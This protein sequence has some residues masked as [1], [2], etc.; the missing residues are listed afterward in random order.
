MN[1]LPHARR[2]NDSASEGGNVTTWPTELAKLSSA[3]GTTLWLD[4]MHIRGQVASGALSAKKILQEAVIALSLAHGKEEPEFLTEAVPATLAPDCRQ[5]EPPRRCDAEFQCDDTDRD[6]IVS[7]SPPMN[8]IRPGTLGGPAPVSGTWQQPFFMQEQ[9]RQQPLYAAHQQ[10][11]LMMAQEPYQGPPGAGFFGTVSGPALVSGTWQLP[12]PNQQQV[13]SSQ[14][15]AEQ[16]LYAAHRQSPLIMA[17][18]PYQPPPGA[19]FAGA[20]GGPAPLFGMMHQSDPRQGQVP[21][22]QGM[23]H[24]LPAVQ[25][26]PPGMA[27]G[28]YQGPPGA[29]YDGTAGDP[30]TVLGMMHQPD[31]RQAQVPPPQGMFQ[32]AAGGAAAANWGAEVQETGPRVSDPD[33]IT[34][35]AQPH[36]AGCR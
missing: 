32:H 28:P 25:L 6:G 20:V 30:G 26:Q 35:G 27:P 36:W 16:P 33:A 3:V 11:A 24:Q 8:A 18:E 22:P 12:F 7:A 21:P 29:G 15:P 1:H 34:S 5:P 31:P 13:L 19:G 10:S 9:V 14:E 17:R 23:I 2:S 4:G